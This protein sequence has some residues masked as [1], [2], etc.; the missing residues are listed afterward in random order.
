VFVAFA[1]GRETARRGQHM[2]DEKQQQQQQGQQKDL[3]DVPGNQ[4]PGTP[5][6]EESKGE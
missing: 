3:G 4:T 6:K 5:E 1:M 2:G